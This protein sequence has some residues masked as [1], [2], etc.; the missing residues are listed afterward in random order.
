MI[1]LHTDVIVETFTVE[2]HLESGVEGE[3]VERSRPI[4]SVLMAMYKPTP[5]RN[6]GLGFVGEFAEGENYVLTRAAM[7]YGIELP[8]N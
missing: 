3:V 4:A 8:C 5:H 1:G 2:K 7:E 6:F